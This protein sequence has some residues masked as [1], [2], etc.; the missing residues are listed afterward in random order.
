[1]T[2]NYGHT[3]THVAVIPTRALKANEPI[4]LTVQQARDMQGAIEV[5]IN[6]LVARQAANDVA[7]GRAAEIQP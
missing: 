2:I 6:K 1:M 7:A 3:E 5:V 4:L